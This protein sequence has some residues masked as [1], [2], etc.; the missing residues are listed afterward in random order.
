RLRMHN[1]LNPVRRQ[2]EQTAGLDYFKTLVHQSRG[3]DGD[4][5]AH[6]PCGM[7]E[8]LLHRD[9]AELRLGYVQKWAAGCGKPYRRYFIERASPHALMNSVV[10]A[11]Y[12]EKWL[13]L[14]S[15]FSR[16]QFAGGNEAFFVR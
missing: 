4:A 7:I 3:I 2:I 10:L 6:L 5:P 12:G 1:H 16:D 8:S 15:R 14:T 11:V 9:G 13:S